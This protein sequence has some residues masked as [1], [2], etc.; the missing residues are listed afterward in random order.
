MSADLPVNHH[1]Y[2]LV[3]SVSPFMVRLAGSYGVQPWTRVTARK[4]TV[5]QM[6]GA[7]IQKG[8]AVFRPA[9]NG[10]NRMHR[11]LAS[12]LQPQIAAQEDT[13]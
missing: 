9:T 6:S 2:A 1:R 3:D 10:Q 12:A 4:A 5:C 7:E 8:D 13:P 11:I